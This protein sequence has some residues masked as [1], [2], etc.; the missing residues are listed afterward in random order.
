MSACPGSIQVLLYPG[1]R[2][3]LEGQDRAV[4]SNQGLSWRTGQGL[5]AASFLQGSQATSH[6]GHCLSTICKPTQGWR[7]SISLPL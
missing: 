5:F 6:P 1:D 2:E 4:L 3:R 7:P